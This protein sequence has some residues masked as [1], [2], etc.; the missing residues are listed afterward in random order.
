VG[1]VE[2]SP[3]VVVPVVGGRGGGGGDGGRIRG[4]GVP[5]R[6]VAP[7]TAIRAAGGMGYALVGSMGFISWRGNIKKIK[8]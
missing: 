1:F 3:F 2:R 8:K 7:R 5:Q 6:P 4:V